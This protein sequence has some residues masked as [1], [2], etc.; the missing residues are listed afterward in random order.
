MAG[1]RDISALSSSRVEHCG[2]RSL[3]AQRR[4]RQHGVTYAAD[5]REG[6]ARAERGTQRCWRGLVARRGCSAH[7]CSSGRCKFLWDTDR[8]GRTSN[9]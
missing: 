9:R 7:R 8:E 2:E 3:R 5:R 1:C 4:A 6:V